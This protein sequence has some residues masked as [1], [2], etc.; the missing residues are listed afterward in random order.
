M[1]PIRHREIELKT[2]QAPDVTIFQDTNE[3]PTPFQP[4]LVGP[5]LRSLADERGFLVG[6][7]IDPGPLANDPE[8][9]ELV[10]REFNILTPEVA[11]KFEVIHPQ[12]GVYDFSRADQ[13]IAFAGENGML[14]RGHPLVWDLQLPHWVLEAYKEDRLNKDEWTELLRSH[15]RTLVEHYRGTI[16]A[17]DVVNE[18]IADDGTL[19]DTIWLRTIGPEYIALAFRWAHE[20]DPQALLFYNDNGGEGLNQKSQGIYEL[21]QRLLR[22]GVPIHGVGFQTHT[23]L[24]GPPPAAELAH[25]MRRLGDLG[26][27]IHITEMDVRLQYSSLPENVKLDQ[28]ARKFA[29]VFQTCLQSPNCEAFVI[30]GPTDLHSWIP[31]HTGQPDAP[32]LF[33]VNYEPKPAYHAILEVLQEGN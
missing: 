9:V 17:W 20:F 10:K 14:V 32:L 11:M 24:N 33:T 8:L 15:I 21:M 6:T 28:Q 25:N 26:L 22:E 3:Q 29:M 12:E 2:Q 4:S 23:W 27:I 5:H 30:W 16:Y 7:A 31:G 1:Y 18:A 19:R 13:I